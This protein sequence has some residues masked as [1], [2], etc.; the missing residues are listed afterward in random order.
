MKLFLIIF[1]VNNAILALGYLKPSQTHSNQFLNRQISLNSE[2][3]KINQIRNLGNSPSMGP[4]HIN[5]LPISYTSSGKLE[6]IKTVLSIAIIMVL[7]SD[8]F[9][10]LKSKFVKN[11]TP[12]LS[13]NPI[14]LPNN[15]RDVLVGSEFLTVGKDITVDMKFT[16]NGMPIKTPYVPREYKFN[17]YNELSTYLQNSSGLLGLEDALQGMKL[18]GMRSIKIPSSIAFQQYE[19]R[20]KY[21]P[22]DASI[23]CDIQILSQ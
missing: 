2:N 6:T 10:V 7:V 5:K 18:N 23:T 22:D 20:P 12:L 17:N 21:I 19:S 9:N 13:A 15:F 8:K 3:E 4:G 1:L 14:N 11:E 16:Y